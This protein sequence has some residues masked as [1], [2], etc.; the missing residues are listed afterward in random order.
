MT[1]YT[2]NI[3]TSIATGFIVYVGIQ[4][5]QIIGELIYNKEL[6]KKKLFSRLQRF[7]EHVF[8]QKLIQL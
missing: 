7:L 6:R 1:S 2:Q 5:K 3:L 8:S 4:K